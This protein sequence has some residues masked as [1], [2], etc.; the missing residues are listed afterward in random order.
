MTVPCLVGAGFWSNLP[1]LSNSSAA[2]RLRAV[3]VKFFVFLLVLLNLLFYAL[4]QGLL[5]QSDNPDA[6]RM[7][8]QIA[9]DRIKIVARGDAPATKTAETVPEPA[10]ESCLRWEQLDIGNA[11]RLEIFIKENFSQLAVKRQ[12]IAGEGS[13]WWVFIPPLP[14]KAEAE[15]KAAELQRLGITDYFIVQDNGA[16]RFAISLGLFSSEKGGQ[17]RLG[18]LKA[19]G[20]RSAK[21]I[22]RPGKDMQYQ[23]EASGPIADKAHLNELLAEVVPK[24]PV[25]ACK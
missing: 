3:L 6:G 21:V 14:G 18:E 8:Q 16:N 11:D 7:Q 15:K 23:I 1:A 12:T 25:L 22:V 24:N 19:K 20:V 17:D 13:S 4:S 9:V 10:T 5:G 2:G